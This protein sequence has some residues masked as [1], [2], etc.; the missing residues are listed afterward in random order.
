M[1]QAALIVL[2]LKVVELGAIATTANFTAWYSRWAPWWRDHIGFTIVAESILLVGALVPTVL[3]L[4]FD[5]S[6]LTSDIAAWTDI[7]LVGLI[8][9]VMIWR[10]AVFRAAHRQ[11]VADRRAAAAQ[12]EGIATVTTPPSLLALT[13]VDLNPGGG[14]ATSLTAAL[15]TSPLGAG[16]TGITFP[17]TGQE[18]VY[19]QTAAT[20][21][22][23]TVT[24]DI[25]TTVEGQPVP[26]IEQDEA[27]STIEMFGPFESV[28]NKQDGTND[29][30]LDF[31]TPANVTG[32]VVVRQP[33][34]S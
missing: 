5:F 23:T 4:F 8:S 13:P 32:V 3:S 30:E 1:T 11:G 6:R 29:V 12:P 15:A 20:S 17:N 33:G 9:P 2:C 10:T 28:F 26:G 24:T 19:V 25:G 16:N 27:A 21:G 22:G 14:P 34:V 7:G 31:G 18:V